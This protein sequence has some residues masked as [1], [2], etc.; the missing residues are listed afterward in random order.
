VVGL[1]TAVEEQTGSTVEDD[2]ISADIFESVGSFSRFIH[3]K[4]A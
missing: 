4:M 3:S 1:I 2:E